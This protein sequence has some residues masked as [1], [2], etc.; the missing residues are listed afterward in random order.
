MKI[1]VFSNTLYT[2]EWNKIRKILIFMLW[3]EKDWILLHFDERFDHWLVVDTSKLVMDFLDNS[4][5]LSCYIQ[6]AK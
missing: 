1:K 5:Q 4:I 2:V 6:G 3:I